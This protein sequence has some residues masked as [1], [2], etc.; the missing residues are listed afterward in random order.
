MITKLNP[1]AIQ[2]KSITAE[3]LS[4]D[5]YTDAEV[6]I[7]LEEVRED[8]QKEYLPIKGGTMT[9]PL[10]VP[11]V[12]GDLKG[13]SDFAKDL[14]GRIEA[15]PEEFTFRP[16]AG[17]KSI[18]DESAVIRSIKGNSVV[19]NNQIGNVSVAS[20]TYR[21]PYGEMIKGNQYLINFSSTDG[22]YIYLY[23]K[24]DGT[25]TNIRF[26]TPSIFT[27]T[28]T[29]KG[30]GTQGD[31]SLWI[32]A[33]GSASNIRLYDLTLMFGAGNEPTTIEEF[34]KRMPQGVDI[35][36][37]NEGEIIDGN[38]EAI[39]TVGFNQW[40]EQWEAGTYSTISGLAVESAVS[41]RSKNPIKCVGGQEYYIS[42]GNYSGYCRVLFY[43]DTMS[44]ISY[45]A[46][47]NKG[48]F[49]T[50][51]NARFIHFGVNTYN[52][53][54][55]NDICINLSHTG[56]RNGEYE[57]YEKH[58]KDLSVIQKYF[59]NGMRSAGSI[60]DE[61]R[62]NETAERWEAV[63]RVGV[64][65]L[66]ELTWGYLSSIL[67]FYT[68]ISTIASPTTNML[69]D[70]F[71]NYPSGVSSSATGDKIM[72]CHANG[73]CRFRD[74]SYGD[75]TTAFTTAMQGVLL[76]YELAEPIITP[77][78]EPIQLD[79][80]VEDFGT[81]K[82]ISTGSST[83]FKADVIY[84]FN[85]TDRIRDNYRNIALLSKSKLDNPNGTSAQF[86]KGDGSLDSNSYCK[87]QTVQLPTTRG[88]IT[89]DVYD[90]MFVADVVKFIYNN[91]QYELTM[92]SKERSVIENERKIIYSTIFFSV[93]NE[94]NVFKL[95]SVS[96]NT[97]SS[98]ANAVSYQV[99]LANL[100]IGA[101][102]VS[103]EV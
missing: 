31:G 5:Y 96:F 78:V 21:L 1:D 79:Y 51:D 22:K 6:D 14:T 55:T 49:T 91:G 3:K 37:Y 47:N 32:Y 35:N 68:T 66:G 24:I 74:T 53:D 89:K 81:E 77:I 4:D 13:T 102:T 85:A 72:S 88:S 63:Q 84:Q 101:A 34:Y 41:L 28:F 99:T 15:T 90:A 98:S 56:V 20:T 46:T 54:Y 11:T 97:P 18:R 62:Y 57:H 75:D 67:S 48:K 64:V 83:P 36:A 25:S 17:D 16:S 103:E 39:E 23:T 60:Y 42:V 33:P 100:A 29:G 59:P 10:T 86:V 69:S 71:V 2:D 76:N 43:D 44:F 65:D 38:Y 30:N 26:D 9:G 45:A 93:S 82:L 50:P 27:S 19:W 58:I 52:R 12:M 94:G 8:V 7:L 95:F 80:W 92:S 70:R 61:I 87:V 40:D 73:L